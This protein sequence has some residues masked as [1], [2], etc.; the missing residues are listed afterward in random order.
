MMLSLSSFL[1]LI[2]AC[3]V[4][5]I[6]HKRETRAHNVN[7]IETVPQS[8]KSN[9]CIWIKT[10]LIQSY[11]LQSIFKFNYQLRA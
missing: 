9:S 10:K 2:L 8:P 6:L 5:A 1:R 11:K 3:K 7:T 4:A